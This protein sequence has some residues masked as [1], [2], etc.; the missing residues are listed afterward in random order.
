MIVDTSLG[1]DKA[2]KATLSPLYDLCL[3]DFISEGLGTSQQK[4]RSKFV[5]WNKN[6]HKKW[7]SKL[8]S[9]TELLFSRSPSPFCSFLPS[10]QEQRKRRE[11]QMK[12][13]IN[14]KLEESGERER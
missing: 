8:R 7:Q 14:Q 6:A 11:S 1:L 2:D 3:T 5:N 4:I 10:Y 13:Q 9:R 12:T